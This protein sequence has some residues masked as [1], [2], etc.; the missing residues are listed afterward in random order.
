[1]YA[2]GVATATID[3]KLQWC[4]SGVQDPCT[5]C[6]ARRQSFTPALIC[7]IIMQPVIKI[8]LPT[9]YP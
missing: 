1:M 5:F 7:S 2:E 8:F 4:L 9:F 3:H 6:M